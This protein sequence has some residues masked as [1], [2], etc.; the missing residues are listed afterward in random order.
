MVVVNAVTAFRQLGFL[1]RLNTLTRMSCPL[2]L[3]GDYNVI[4]DARLDYVGQAEILLKCFQLS[5]R[6]RLLFPN[7]AIGTLTIHIGSSI[8]YL[9]EI[10]YSICKRLRIAQ[11]ILISKSSTSHTAN[12]GSVR[13]S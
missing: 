1:R 11:V 9:S 7:V 10:K 4:L 2:M 13:S 5:D 12:L 3:V 8:S 6:Y